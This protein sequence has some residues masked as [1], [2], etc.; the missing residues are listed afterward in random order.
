MSETYGIFETKIHEYNL[1][2]KYSDIHMPHS[3]VLIT[4]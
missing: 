2:V 3:S 4:V 1:I